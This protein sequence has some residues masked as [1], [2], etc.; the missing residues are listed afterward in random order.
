MKVLYSKSENAF[1]HLDCAS[2]KFRKYHVKRRL[3][4][5]VVLDYLN[6][7][8]KVYR[9]EEFYALKDIDLHI[10][11]G[12]RLGVVG[13]N[14]AGKSTL[15]KV[16]AGVY[17]LCEGSLTISGN[18]TPMIELGTGFNPELSGRENILLNG[19]MLGHSK[20][21]MQDKEEEIVEFAE[22]QEFIDMPVKYYSSGM[23]S[24]LAFSIATAV[25]PDILIVDEVLSAGDAHFTQKASQKINSL[26][27][28]STIVLFVSHNL[29]SVISLCNKAILLEKG[30]IITSG[31]PS[32]V[33]EMYKQRI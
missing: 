17:S 4:R 30:R 24:R 2:L 8:Q 22:L 16:I 14:G 15:L 27:S 20:K 9:F 10:E 32:S 25:N 1:I 11:R 6:H 5:D 3:L 21:I 12:D 7:R 13:A 29:N 19:A 31:E 18:I 23:Y 26:F 33:I 28:K